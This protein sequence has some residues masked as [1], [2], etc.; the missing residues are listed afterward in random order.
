MKRRLIA[1]SLCSALLVGCGNK[2]AAKEDVAQAEKPEENVESDSTVDSQ[3]QT[4]YD[5][6]DQWEI[7]DWSMT[8]DNGETV[9]FNDY[10]YAVTDLDWD[11]NYEIVM[12]GFA[13]SGMFTTNRIYEYEDEG[14]IVEW[15]TSGLAYDDSEPDL[16]KQNNL[17]NIEK[18]NVGNVL[19]GYISE[20]GNDIEYCLVDY[21]PYGASG[22]KKNYLR[23]SVGDN[24]LS[25]TLC[26]QHEIYEGKCK[27]FDGEG[28]RICF[29]ELHWN[30]FGGLYSY[31][32]QYLNVDWFYE[33]TYDNIRLSAEESKKLRNIEETDLQMSQFAEIALNEIIADNIEINVDNA[34]LDYND[35]DEDTKQL[36]RSFLEGDV[37]AIF[38]DVNADVSDRECLRNGLSVGKRY[39]IDELYNLFIEG[40]EDVIK[41]KIVTATYIDCGMDGQ[42]EFYVRIGTDQSSFGKLDLILK[43]KGGKLYICLAT[44]CAE[45]KW[46]G[47]YEN[48]FYGYM[49]NINGTRHEGSSY[50]VDA[51]GKINYLY[52]EGYDRLDALSDDESEDIPYNQ[53]SFLSFNNGTTYVYGIYLFDEDGDEIENNSENADL[54]ENMK[55]IFEERGYVV[56]SDEEAEGMMRDVR[57]KAGLSDEINEAEVNWYA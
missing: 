41:E 12:S 54:Y 18:Q 25:S 29:D 37:K 57:I 16:M 20:D 35:I 27:C 17:W 40:Y 48:G 3:I 32:E 36:Y 4:L 51:S 30:V 26:A 46:S 43:D 56:I 50:Y 13:G 2:D 8:L 33:V 23:V 14:K 34:L 39:S 31:E 15:D 22:G 6:R 11:G 55:K 42:Y 52:D 38:N 10:G 1:I 7:V 45:R 5:T 53:F 44:D 19:P 49:W 28:N 47:L 9:E 21:E 24:S